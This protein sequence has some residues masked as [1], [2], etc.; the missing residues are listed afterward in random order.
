MTKRMM[1]LQ[2]KLTKVI[3]FLR[4]RGKIFCKMGI[5][6]RFGFNAY[7]ND[8][9]EIGN[10]NYVGANTVI[11]YAI[12]GNYCSIAPGVK[13]G[14]ANHDYELITTSEIVNKKFGIDGLF[15]ERTIIGSDVWV[16]ADAIIAQGVK[17]GNGAV[18]GAGSFVNRDV[19]DFAIVVGTPA[20]L[21]KYRF[22]HEKINKISKSAWWNSNLNEAIRIIDQLKKS[23]ETNA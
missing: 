16:G 6:N 5:E 11:S 2:R 4:R 21:L 17:I 18:I 15:S 12:I 14:L 19:P 9:C 7:L 8:I 1:I 20:R 22:N 23:E 3:L 10:Y 13:I